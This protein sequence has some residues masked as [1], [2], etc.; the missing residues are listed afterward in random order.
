MNHKAQDIAADPDLYN[1]VFLIDGEEWECMGFTKSGLTVKF[2][3]L[4]HQPS[5]RV[6]QMNKYMKPHQYIEPIND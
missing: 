6:T 4:V 5:G 3:R 1:R 2:S